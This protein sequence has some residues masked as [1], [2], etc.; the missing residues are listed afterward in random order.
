FGFRRFI[1]CLGYKGWIIKRYFLDYHLHGADLTINLGSNSSCRIRANECEEDWE[2]TLAET[3]LETMTGGRVKAVARYLD[4]SHFML[5]YGDGVT[6]IDL[7]ELLS[8]H[9]RQCLI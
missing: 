7:N 6:D 5:T 8:F 3:G 2:V 9:H 4:S 1:L